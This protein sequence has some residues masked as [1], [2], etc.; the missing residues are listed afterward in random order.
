MLTVRQRCLRD[1]MRNG[2]E[3]VRQEKYWVLVHSR[4]KRIPPGYEWV[5]HKTVAALGRRD[6]LVQV[7]DDRYRLK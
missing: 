1:L 4:L 3:L 7:S 5:E 2:W 6:M